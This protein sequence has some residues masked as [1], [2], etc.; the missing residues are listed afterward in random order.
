MS[1]RLRQAQEQKQEQRLTQSITQQQLLQLKLIELPVAQLLERIDTEMNENPALDR[2][3]S[4]DGLG[5]GDDTDFPDDM[6]AADGTESYEDQR[7]HEDRQA[8]MDEAWKRVGGEDEELPVHTPYSNSGTG[9]MVYGNTTSFH[10]QLKEQMGFAHLTE[11]ENDIM[12]YLIGSLDDD[13]LLRK[14]LDTIVEE[15]AFRQYIY[16]TVEEVEKVLKELQ[17]FDPAGIGAQSLQECLLLQI[18]RRKNSEMKKLMRQVVTNYFDV[19]FTKPHWDKI[20][21]ALK[22]S[23]LQAEQL[24]EEL[25]RLNPKPGAALGETIGSSQQQITPDFIVDTHDDGTITFSLNQDGMP[26]LQVSQSYTDSIR[27]YENRKGPLSSQAKAE[28]LTIKKQATAAR[29]FIEALRMR[30]QTL[31]ATMR[32]IIQ[33]Q[34]R[35]FLEGDEASL[36]PMKLDDVSERTGI[37]RSTIS[38]VSNSKYVQTRW[39]IYPLRF[40]F[41]N[42][43]TNEQGED[44]STRQVKAALRELIEAEDQRKPL[45]DEALT[46]LMAARG[47]AIARRTVAKYRDQMGI[48]VARQ[49]KTKPR[50]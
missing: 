38:R 49:R 9:E 34:H 26:E 8:A 20:Q 25:R 27:A 39:G 41:S 5:M 4:P 6:D 1:T 12:E 37:G 7:D 15:L 43:Y 40:F 33:L 28:Q 18:E 35:F 21:S 3:D 13:G 11:Q 32:A 19:F 45:S 17:Q 47:Y 10:D 29:N 23:D 14:P 2:V 44:L 24:F 16:V 50:K 22:L 36:K 30:R 42:S 31:T 48:P 46:K